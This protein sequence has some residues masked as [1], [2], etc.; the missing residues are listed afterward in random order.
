MKTSKRNL[1]P[2]ELRDKPLPEWT[3]AERER[4]EPE[5]MVWNRDRQEWTR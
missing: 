5:G 1:P 4:H 3:H 2:R